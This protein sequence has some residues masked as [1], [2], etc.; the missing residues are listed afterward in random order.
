M[1]L[2]HILEIYYSHDGALIKTLIDRGLMLLFSMLLISI[3]IGESMYQEYSTY[4]A[5]STDDCIL[6]VPR[7]MMTK[8]NGFSLDTGNFS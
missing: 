8:F 6:D 3:S 4:R 1:F 5:M 7:E 2:I